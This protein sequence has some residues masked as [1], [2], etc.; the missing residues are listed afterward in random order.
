M[1]IQNLIGVGLII[2]PIIGV[3]SY[4]QLYKQEL[5]KKKELEKK[6]WQAKQSLVEIFIGKWGK[7]NE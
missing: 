5:V 1:S 6:R 2:T 4:W 3:F 7:E